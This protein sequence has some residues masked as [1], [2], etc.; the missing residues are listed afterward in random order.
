MNKVEFVTK[1]GDVENKLMSVGVTNEIR[2]DSNK[3]YS[4]A[5]FEA[6]ESGIPLTVEVEEMLRK[7]KL[8][9]DEVDNKERESLIKQ[10]RELEVQLR[11]AKLGNRRMSKVEGREVALKM[12]HLRIKLVGLSQTKSALFNNTAENIA[13]NTRLNYYVYRCTLKQGSLEPYWKSYDEFKTDTENPV[14]GDA[15]KYFISLMTGLDNSSEK[16]LYENQWLVRMKFMDD[17]LQLV[18][19]K[20]RFVDEKGKLI[21]KDGRYVSENGSFVDS[22]GNPLDTDGNLDIVDG[23]AETAPAPDPVPAPMPEPEKVPIAQ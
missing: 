4:A 15:V 14:Y 23:W 18:D 20:G 8:L 7:K 21:D 10:L 9:D 5:F 12:K 3:V 1:V 22:F 2:S 19:D 11:S 13:E 6:V 17:N 16:K